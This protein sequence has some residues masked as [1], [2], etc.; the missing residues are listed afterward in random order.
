MKPHLTAAKHTLDHGMLLRCASTSDLVIYNCYRRLCGPQLGRLSRHSPVHFELHR[1]SGRQPHL[2]VLETPERHLLQSIEAEH[3]DVVE[4]VGF[5]SY[6]WS[7]TTPCHWPLSSNATTATSST[8]PPTSSNINAPSMLGLIS[9]SS[10][11]A[12]PLESQIV[13]T[14]S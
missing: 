10:A 4:R 1:V 7:Y 12:L 3:H 11:S 2:L 13:S 8:S 9:T 5:I 6:L 14:M